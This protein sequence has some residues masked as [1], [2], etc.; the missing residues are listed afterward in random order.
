MCSRTRTYWPGSKGEVGIGD[1][2]ARGDRAGR[3]VDHIVEE[4]Q[5]A[6]ADGV[7]LS[8]QGNLRLDL[9][10]RARLR[11]LGQIGF[12]RVERDVDRIELHERVERS[13]RRADQRAYRRL[14][15][16][17]PAG[18]RGADF[19]I[20][21]IELRG[22]DRGLIHRQR[23]LGL[24]HGA[25]PLIEGVLGDEAAL[26]QFLAAIEI[27][28]RIVERRGVA[29]RL[30]FGLVERRLQVARIDLVEEV[31]ALDVGAVGGELGLDVAG[32][33]RLQGDAAD[34]F[35]AGRDNRDRSAASS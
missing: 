19:G 31:A 14:I 9:A 5:F 11:D 24:M 4:G 8:G 21:E 20:A 28:L 22:L 35:D 6:L 30:R 12:A 2:H 18:E 23:R 16:P 34:Q 15:A 25:R 13:A 1:G 10:R 17:Q 3:L 33:P 27:G 29:L 7:G 26:G 32:H